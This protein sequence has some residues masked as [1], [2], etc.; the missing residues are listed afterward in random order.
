MEV[1]N[2]SLVSTHPL[3][4]E[5]MKPESNLLKGK[6]V[7]Y[8]FLHI[9]VMVVFLLICFAL[10]SCWNKEG[11]SWWCQAWRWFCKCCEFTS[12][13]HRWRA[14]HNLHRECF[15]E[16]MGQKSAEANN[17][18]GRRGVGENKIC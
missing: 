3:L 16:E 18:R 11:D 8:F 2:S 5:K 17:N 15:Q 4:V 6:E 12:R 14:L 1:M 10:S 13:T 7:P 9:F